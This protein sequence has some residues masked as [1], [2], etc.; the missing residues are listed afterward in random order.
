[1]II[2]KDIS[3]AVYASVT[4][5]EIVNKSAAWRVIYSDGTIW[6]VANRLTH[7]DDGPSFI[8]TNG[9]VKYYYHNKYYGSNKDFTDEQWI[10]FCKLKAFI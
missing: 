5:N 1:M 8:Y 4:S 10:R 6:Y 7:R 2:Y 3:Y 9:D